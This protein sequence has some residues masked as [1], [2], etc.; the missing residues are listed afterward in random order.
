MR[1]AARD[2]EKKIGPWLFEPQI[3]LIKGARRAGKTTL[4]TL[5]KDELQK[6]GKKTAYFA[7]DQLIHEPFWKNSSVFYNFLRNEY[8]L[9][10][11]TPLF[12]FL[13][14]I[15][16]LEDPG[17]FLK[18]LYDVAKGRLKIL[19]TGS[20]TLELSKTREFL[21][22]RKIEFVLERFSFLEFWRLQSGKDKVTTFE[23][24]EL[25]ALNDFYQAYYSRLED[26]F[27]EYL[28]WGGYPEVVLIKGKHKK[29]TMLKNI[30]NT[31]LEK[32]VSVL[33]HLQN[34]SNFNK[35]IRLLASQVGELLNKKELSS[36][37]SM[38]FHTLVSY[39][40]LLSGTFVFDLVTPFFSNVRKELSKM[41]KV[42][43]RDLG[44]IQ[45]VRPDF[46]MDY[47]LIDGHRVENFVYRHLLEHFD[48]NE[49]HFYR[50]RG[51][52]EID[53][54]VTSATGYILIEV[55]FRKGRQLKPPRAMETFKELYGDQVHRRIV[56]TQD[57]LAYK[58]K[59]LFIPAPLFPF[60]SF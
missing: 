33:F 57:Y 12:V 42:F 38:H 34:I 45:C 46:F 23:A 36:T 5:I 54:V 3:I 22:G 11:D 26:A 18:T 30:L 10:S 43:A 35:L 4:L 29:E 39:L 20:S 58:G 49:I 15:Q 37:L 16:Y 8:D 55:R 24:D 41:P 47:T 7:I 1:T 19:V 13:D 59:C 25:A 50:K 21:P 53:F 6:E 2:L 52:A 44:I 56:V 32:D 40:D 31:Y 60:L 28:T 14:E 17:L 27:T 9:E 51:G 48:T